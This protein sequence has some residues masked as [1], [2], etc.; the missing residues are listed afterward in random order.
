MLYASKK[1]NHMCH[2]CSQLLTGRFIAHCLDM[3]NQRKQN[4]HFDG[5]SSAIRSE[6][7]AFI[8]LLFCFGAI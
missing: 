2:T 1:S 8:I 3:Y 6:N 5:I 7:L 4:N